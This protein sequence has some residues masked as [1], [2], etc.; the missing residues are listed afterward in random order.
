MG[1]KS[2]RERKRHEDELILEAGKQDDFR[3]RCDDEFVYLSSHVDKAIR[4]KIH[5]GEVDID[6]SKL[7]IKCKLS[8]D[9]KLEI[10]NKEGKSFFVPATECEIPVINSFKR[11]EQAFHIFSGIYTKNRPERVNQLY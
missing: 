6:L 9:N 1:P 3:Y 4:D 10:I 11:W 5:N 7:I 2:E 8:L